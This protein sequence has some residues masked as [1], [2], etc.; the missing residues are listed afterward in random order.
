MLKITYKKIV[1]AFKNF[2]FPDVDFVVGIGTGGL[3]PASM[4]AYHLDKEIA[5]FHVNYR[6]DNNQPQHKKPVFLES[7]PIHQG[8]K[9]ILL[10]DDVSVTGKTLDAVK[11]KLSAYHVQ[12]FVLVGLADFVLFPEIKECVDWPWKSLKNKD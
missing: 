8:V 5:Y 4:A 6:D 7:Q 1:N 3:I 9:N 11:K 12:T 10:I 2:S